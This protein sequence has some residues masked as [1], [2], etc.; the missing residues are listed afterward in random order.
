MIKILV[1]RQTDPM[2]EKILQEAVQNYQH[3]PDHK[4]FVI[5]PN[6]IKFTTEVRAINRVAT[7]Q[8]HTEQSVKNLQVLSFSRLAWFFLKDAK[9]GL[10]TELDNAAAAMLLAKIIDQKK[11]Q[12]HFFQ[13][14]DL[15]PG[16]I[17]QLYDTILQV[18]EGNL[19][20][21]DIDLDTLELETKIKFLISKLSIRLLLKPLRA[22]FLPQM[23]SNCS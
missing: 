10:P 22:N 1:G 11:E 14:T 16:L 6:H 8:K 4:T 21:D 3:F 15:N 12:L 17:K 13:T 5:V 18:R 23:R 9:K 2:Q 19:N 20:L 7:S